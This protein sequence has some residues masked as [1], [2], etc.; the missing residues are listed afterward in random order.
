MASEAKRKHLFISHH[1]KDDAEVTKLIDLISGKGYDIRN[2][3]IRVKPKN[4]KRLEQK[5]VDDEVIRRLLRMKISWAGSVVV[6]IGKETHQREWVDWELE[7][8]NKQG[9]RIVGVFVSG[10][11]EADIPK[12]FEAYGS[13]LVKWNGDS[14]VRALEGENNFENPDGTTRKATNTGATTKCD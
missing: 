12:N 9:K 5:K 1:H 7:Q 6:L 8:A 14:I 11:S 10:G 3:S 13:A 2:S 4:Q